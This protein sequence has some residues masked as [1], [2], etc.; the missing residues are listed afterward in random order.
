[1]NKTVIL[2]PTYNERAN[3]AL[4]VPEIFSLHPQVS[5]MVIDDASP[6]GTGEEVRQL[7]ERY[8]N[9]SL[10]AR[11]G[12]QG[13]GTAYKAAFEKVLTDRNVER[14]ITMDADGSHAA[15]YLGALIEK[16][17]SHDLVI[18]SRYVRGGSIED[19]EAWRYVLS[20]GGNLYARLIT[21]LPVRDMTAGF[22]CFRTA[23]LRR[24]DLSSMQASG[25]AFLMELKF[26]TIF[27]LQ[28]TLA[29][30]PI[31]F[32]SRREG[33]SKLS[34]HIIR[35][36]L[37]TPWRLL[38]RRV[39]GGLRSIT[40]SADAPQCTICGSHLTRV[41]GGKNNCTLYECM[42]CRLV[43]VHPIPQNLEQIYGK[44]Y[45]K[46]EEGNTA[47]GYS[48]Y[49]KDKEPMRSIF[50][51]YIQKCETYVSG[52]KLFDVGAATGYV[53]NIA[54]KRGW[55][56]YG[57]ELSSYAAGVAASRGHQMIQGR[58]TKARQLPHVDAVMMWDVLEHVDDPRAY[59]KA[60]NTMLP[61]GG[62]LM[63]STPDK[64]SLW[65]R[66]MGMRWQLIVP[67]EH[68]FYYSPSNLSRLLTECGF[69][70]KEIA[71]PSKRFSVPYVFSIL[72]QWQ[73]LALWK[74]LARATDNTL[75]RS[76]ALPIN[77]RD[78]MF[79]VAKKR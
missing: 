6:D 39:T 75:F 47:H 79:I 56:T 41:F 29:E 14:I 66:L 60:V 27:A 12:K 57:S 11:A 9:L 72:A 8:P 24:M 48:D 51:W 31:H 5:I 42:G 3:I 45:F 25:Y 77:L 4:L 15:E 23:L 73:K 17:T 21:G 33:E 71:K 35:E 52:R 55:Q 59:I 10:L 76:F 64:S 18:G 38:W 13:L 61:M 54:K 70:V 58:L 44:E 53:L 7:T 74:F 28:G 22:M 2:I 65:S 20:K 1:M 19:W 26:D 49:D 40:R 63:I 34:R 50:E 36:G 67:P 16:S 46:K 43:F 78:N 30:I 69:E 62:V 68:L 32:H 37:K